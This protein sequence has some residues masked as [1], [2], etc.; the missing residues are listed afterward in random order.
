MAAPP[1]GTYSSTD[2]VSNGTYAGWNG[3]FAWDGTN[4]TYTLSSNN[5]TLPAVSNLSNGDA[6]VF[7]LTYNN[8]TVRINVT[9]N[10]S[11]Y[12]GRCH[13]PNK[14]TDDSGDDWTV[15]SSSSEHF[16]AHAR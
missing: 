1:N 13:D 9:K 12:T 11:D 6:F 16:K 8:N 10:G 4:I 14:P 7:N 5:T 2:D 3:S 15:K